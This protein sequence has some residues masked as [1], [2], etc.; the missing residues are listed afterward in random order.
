LDLARFLTSSEGASLLAAARAIRDVP[1]HR[2]PD[3]LAGR[4]APDRIRAA[5]LQD[6]L[7]RRALDRCPHAERLLFTRDALEQA[8]AWPVAAERATRWPAGLEAMLTDLGAGIGLDA[9]AVAETGRP[10]RA[11]ERDPVRGVLLRHNARALG[12]GSRIEV[13][14][15][16]V[17]QAAPRGMLAFLDPDRRPGGR[18]THDP[19]RFEPPMER[20]QGLVDRFEAVIVKLSPTMRPGAFAD[21]PSEV[22]SLAGRARERRVFVGAFADLPRRRALQLPSGAAIAGDGLPWPAPR[23]PREGDWLLDPDPAVTLAG[24]VGDLAARDALRPIHPRIAF[25][26]GPEPSPCAPGTW[27]R[28]EARLPARPREI[29]AWLAAREIGNLTLR[30]RGVAETAASW[31]RRLRAH[32]PH[33]GAVVLTRGPADR[34][35]A[36]GCREER[37]PPMTR[38]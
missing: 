4:A 33:A 24:L 11:Y 37:S 25:L 32:G 22:V 12:L 23:D 17:L 30:T 15:E 18:R 2:R 26:V 10:V 31:R 19:G 34:W 27:L 14:E 1:A 20:W 38:K 8:T 28:I 5:L 9:L 21:A 35:V 36:L 3:A 6:D 13:R 7:R 29:N 16:D